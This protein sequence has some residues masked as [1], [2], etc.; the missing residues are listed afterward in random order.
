MSQSITINQLMEQ[1]KHSDKPLSMLD[2]YVN[3]KTVE[4]MQNNISEQRKSS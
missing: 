4:K 3:K 2:M 1:P